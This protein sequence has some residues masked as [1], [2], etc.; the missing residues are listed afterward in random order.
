MKEWIND[1]F[2][3]ISCKCG[4]SCKGMWIGIALFLIIVIMVSAS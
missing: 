1:K 3:K 2:Q 4:L